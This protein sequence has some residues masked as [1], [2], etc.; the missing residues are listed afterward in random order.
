[1]IKGNVTINVCDGGFCHD[2]KVQNKKKDHYHGSY[3]YIFDED[4]KQGMSFRHYGI[5]RFHVIELK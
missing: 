2:E 4:T 1:M 3:A 5:F